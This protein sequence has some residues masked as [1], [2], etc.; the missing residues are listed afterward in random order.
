MFRHRFVTREI[1]TLLLSRFER[2]PSLKIAWTEGLR[3]DVCFLVIQKTGHKKTRSVYEYFHH[4]YDL[5]TGQS[6]RVSIMSQ[7]DR[8]DAAQE[9]LIDLK[10]KSTIMPGDGVEQ[11]IQ[12]LESDIESLYKKIYGYRT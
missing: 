3:E 12:E 8:L 11:E 5:L 9:A 4:E 7:R 10:F 6:D 2:T 1:H